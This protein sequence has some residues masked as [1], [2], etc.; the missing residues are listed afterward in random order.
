M[1]PCDRWVLSSLMTAATKPNPA[2][3]AIPKSAALRPPLGGSP[4]RPGR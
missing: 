1:D 4:L 2:A 3:A